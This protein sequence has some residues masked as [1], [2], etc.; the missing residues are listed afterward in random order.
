MT[1]PSGEAQEQL[2]R[3]LYEPCGVTPE[4]LEY[5]EA[6]GTGT[7]V[8]PLRPRCPRPRL[9]CPLQ[10]DPPVSPTGG[11]P[12][13]AEWHRP[14]TVC[15]PPGPPADRVHQVEHGAP[16]AGLGA[17]RTGQGGHSLGQGSGCCAWS[18]PW[19]AGPGTLLGTSP[20]GCRQAGQLPPQLLSRVGTGEPR[21]PSLGSWGWGAS[22]GVQAHSHLG[23]ALAEAAG[24]G[25]VR[26]AGPAGCLGVSGRHAAHRCCCPWSTGSGRPTCTSTA[27]TPRS[28]RCRRGGCRWWTGP[29]PSAGGTWP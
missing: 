1:F 28:Q 26:A 13:G 22:W 19:F 29:C 3:S 17:G 2:I 16:G 12:P 25:E 20:Q 10:P 6:H 11:R 5:I 9:S 24:V 7:K 18:L 27:R 4:S 15:H 23:G 14:G 21:P 8:R